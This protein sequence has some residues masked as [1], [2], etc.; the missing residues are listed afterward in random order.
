MLTALTGSVTHTYPNANINFGDL[1]FVASTNSNTL[2]G[3]R[4]HIVGGSNNEV[5]GTDV[6]LVNT[7]N[8]YFTSC[9]NVQANNVWWVGQAA[10]PPSKNRISYIGSSFSEPVVFLSNLYSAALGSVQCLYTDAVAA[11]GTSYNCTLD[12]NNT[13]GATNCAPVVIAGTIGAAVHDIE[14]IVAIGT[15]GYLCP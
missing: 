9:T 13:L 4:T 8:S 2:S 7:S 3:T 5:S 12:G 1:S 10:N 11:N 6:A 15:G 14:F